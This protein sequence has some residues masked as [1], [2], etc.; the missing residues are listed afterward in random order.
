M[1]P[2]GA[3]VPLAAPHID[4]PLVKAIARA[5]RWQKMLETGK[6]ATIREIAKAERINPSYVLRVLRLTLLAPATVEAL[7]E[8]RASAGPT[9]AEV[10]G[11]SGRVGGTSNHPSRI[12]LRDG[13]EYEV[14]GETNPRMVCRRGI[15]LGMKKFETFFFCTQA[16]YQIL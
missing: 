8:G 16:F 1:A 2:D 5:F 6:Y 7:L 13:T 11:V 10:M 12:K 3:P 14:A 9:L 15:I 4:G